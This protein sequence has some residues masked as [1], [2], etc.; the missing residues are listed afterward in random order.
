RE[1]AVSYFGEDDAANLVNDAIFWRF[2]GAPALDLMD[3][4]LRT[5]PLYIHALERALRLGMPVAALPWA[6]TLTSIIA[7]AAVLVTSYFLFRSLAGR[8]AAAVATGLLALTPGMWLGATYGM[9]HIPGLAFMMASLLLVSYVLDDDPRTVVFWGRLAAAVACAFVGLGFKA[10][11][12][13]M[14]GAFPGL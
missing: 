13:L 6:M 2:S 4:R 5:S 12:I 7:S 10:D 1:Y 3:Y 9:A 8:S 14:G 11:L